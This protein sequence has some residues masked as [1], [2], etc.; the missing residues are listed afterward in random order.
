MQKSTLYCAAED[1][2][3]A[4]VAGT[5]TAKEYFTYKQE[6]LER[7]SAAER[8]AVEAFF[9]RRE[10]GGA[11]PFSDYTFAPYGAPDWAVQTPSGERADPVA[12][13]Q[14]VQRAGHI[15]TLETQQGN[16][17]Q[18]YYRDGV[19]RP[20]TEDR[21]LERIQHEIVS[22]NK[23]LYKG[24]AVREAA[25]MIAH[26]T[27]TGPVSCLD[28]DENLV[29]FGNC[30]LH[31]DT[32]ETEPH[33]PRYYS[34]VQLHADWTEK[35]E[36]TPVFNAFLSRLCGADPEKERLLK[37][38]M[39]LIL[40]NVP[41]WRT[42]KALFLVG[43]GNTGKS[44]LRRL[45]EQIL[46]P[47]NF[48]NADLYTLEEDKFAAA[49]L[50][51]R[52][53][54]GA[55]DMG[56]LKMRQLAVFKQLTGGDSVYAQRKGKDPFCF[57]FNGLLWFCMNEAPRFGGDQ[58]DW[59]YDRILLFPCGEPVPADLQDPDLLR[60]LLAEKNGIVHALISAAKEVIEAGYRFAVPDSLRDANA[61][62]RR[63]N[64]PARQFFMDCCRLRKTPVIDPR[65]PCTCKNV[66]EAFRLWCR[67]NAPGYAPKKGGF[68]AACARL[69]AIPEEKIVI[70]KPT[71]RY[72]IF[73][74]TQEVREEYG[75]MRP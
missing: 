47:E 16:V 59:V 6:L 7:E 24:A 34:T 10:S 48:V 55:S 49:E 66:F 37:Q 72:Y 32:M 64:D 63:E 44:V 58:G 45:I 23:K 5:V 31:L 38:F 62:Y 33:A 39:G 15:L 4:A 51:G 54:A 68:R 57:R 12:L 53:L 60:K 3:A 46:G 36:E 30:V 20:C 17:R 9:R 67:D 65:D 42:K 74:L 43:A 21:L 26:A 22:Y 8:P 35:P 2:A 50:E 11:E 69:L 14:A 71:Q 25:G 52:R 75:V 13:A 29:N 27:P 56:F 40:T 41:G 73:E 28:T 18:Y 1:L 70:R 61:G 19:Y